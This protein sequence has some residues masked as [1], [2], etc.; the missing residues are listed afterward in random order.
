MAL[1]YVEEGGNSQLSKLILARNQEANRGNKGS[2]NETVSIILP[3]STFNYSGSWGSLFKMAD[4]G[5]LQ[6]VNVIKQ[7]AFSSMIEDHAAAGCQIGRERTIFSPQRVRLEL[8]S[9]LFK[10]D[11]SQ[12]SQVKVDRKSALLS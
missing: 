4:E 5:L 7:F 9:S 3:R 12:S 6:G 11:R 2:S 1:D 8:S 10:S